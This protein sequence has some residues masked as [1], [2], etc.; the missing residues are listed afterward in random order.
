MKRVSLF[1][2]WV[3]VGAVLSYAWFYAVTPLGLALI[4]LCLG[5]ASLV[6][7]GGPSTGPEILGLLAGAGAFSL[8]VA[9]NVDNE[10]PWVAA[11]VLFVALAVGGYAAALVSRRGS[12]GRAAG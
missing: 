7:R 8:L 11:G 3:C 4:A 6:R 1:L 10:L 9:T 12:A 5:A 2:A